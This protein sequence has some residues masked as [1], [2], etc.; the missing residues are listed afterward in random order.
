MIPTR[1]RLHKTPLAL[2]CL[3]VLVGASAM[4][5]IA[6]GTEYTPVQTSLPIN[7]PFATQNNIGEATSTLTVGGV[8]SS[9]SLVKCS[10][11]LTDPH[12]GALV[13]TLTSPDGDTVVLADNEG[14]AH[15]GN[16]FTAGTGSYGLG[17]AEAPNG[18]VMFDDNAIN[19]PIDQFRNQ[20][21]DFIPSAIYNPTALY[22]YANQVWLPN[23][24]RFAN[25]LTAGNPLGIVAP[26]GQRL[27]QFI[28]KADTNVNGTWTLRVEDHVFQINNN[29]GNGGNANFQTNGSLVWWTLSVEEFGVHTWTGG[30]FGGFGTQWSQ[31]QNWNNNAPNAVEQK[32]LLDFPSNASQFVIN[33]D[34]AN[35]KIGQAVIDGT[36]T[37]TGQAVTL[38]QNAFIQNVSG[39]TSWALAS[40]VSAGGTTFEVDAGQLLVSGALLAPAVAVTTSN[41]TK[42]GAGVLALSGANTYVGTTAINAG[43]LVALSANALGDL[44]KGTTVADGATLQLGP[45]GA[46]STYGALNNEPLTLIGLGLGGV[47][48]LENASTTAITVGSPITLANETASVGAVAGTSLTL[49]GGTL[50]GGG[51][52]FQGAGTLNLNEALPGGNLVAS[53]D[54]TG[55]GGTIVMQTTTN[56][57]PNVGLYNGS[58]LNLGT[59]TLTVTNSVTSGPATTVSNA[60]ISGVGGTLTLGAGPRSVNV[61][62]GAGTVPDLKISAATVGGTGSILKGGAGNLELDNTGGAVSAAVASGTLSGT[63][64]VANLD[65]SSGANVDPGVAGAGTLTASGN[66]GFAAGS[67]FTAHMA[68]GA[69]LAVTGNLTLSGAVADGAGGAFLR[70]VGGAAGA[71]V[72]ATYGTLTPS[73][74]VGRPYSSSTGIDYLTG[75]SITMSLDGTSVGLVQNSFTVDEGVGSFPVTVTWTG[76]GSPTA[77]LIG[78]DGTAS[79]GRKYQQPTPTPLLGTGNTTF[80]VPITDNYIAEGNQYFTLFLIPLGGTTVDP[81][82]DRATV[83][84]LDNDDGG[85]KKKCGIGSGFTVFFLFGFG[86]LLRALAL[87]RR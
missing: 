70:P 7:I 56:S 69:K 22:S 73:A 6:P 82:A 14:N 68:A 26:A 77:D 64:Q 15:L 23:G 83:T 61:G 20:T 19:N 41:I 60:I 63:G 1:A 84:I 80:T 59:N 67:I 4:P 8:L 65:V 44:T 3:L 9:I 57:V 11:Y 50:S 74:F 5:V 13:I 31:D 45:A 37:I 17:K 53:G 75:N 72:I 49:A 39:N 54:A 47:G 35:L 38:T 79:L 76:G 12:I 55:A 32:V 24:F 78:F 66:A 27:A 46:V 29:N 62:A 81:A 34:V 16:D 10:V 25:N 33:N 52:Y 51:L 28:G 85:K 36:Y 40:T 2:S 71:H 86:L 18:M 42:T 87:R 21:I 43:T 30:A 58:T 48:A